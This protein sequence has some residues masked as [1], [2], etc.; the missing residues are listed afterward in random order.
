MV[1]THKTK[2][3]SLL[4][5]FILLKLQAVQGRMIHYAQ[6]SSEQC[7]FRV[8]LDQEVVCYL[9]DEALSSFNNCTFLC[10]FVCQHWLKLIQSIPFSSYTKLVL[11][12][13]VTLSYAFFFFFGSLCLSSLMYSPS[14]QGQTLNEQVKLKFNYTYC[15]M[16]L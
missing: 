13:H 2:D 12:K 5:V 16:A 8:I 1:G 11:W 14:Y 10:A 4:T 7:R 3:K 9:S 6:S 15:T